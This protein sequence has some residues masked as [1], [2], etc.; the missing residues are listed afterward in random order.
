MCQS[1]G[2]I[3][4]RL[5][6]SVLILLFYAGACAPAVGKWADDEVAYLHLLEDALERIDG[7]NST[8]FATEGD[9]SFVI[10]MRAVIKKVKAWRAPATLAVLGNEVA[11]MVDACSTVHDSY[12][13][14]QFYAR[15]DA[16]LTA[17]TEAIAAKI[18][19]RGEYLPTPTPGSP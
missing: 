8:I 1:S 5:W 17:V 16:A 3:K 15:C 14:H 13:S 10:D 19:E 18:E 6:L 7:Y 2:C 9:P 12:G 4:F 11:A